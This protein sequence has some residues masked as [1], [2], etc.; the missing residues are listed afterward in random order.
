M[1]KTKLTYSYLLW[2]V[3]SYRG[4]DYVAKGVRWP[5]R[6]EISSVPS[7]FSQNLEPEY[8]TLNKDDTI[9]YIALQVN[10]TRPAVCVIT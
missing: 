10:C 7:T 5:Y 2:Y 1:L 9:A 4:E 3:S 6:G 8:I